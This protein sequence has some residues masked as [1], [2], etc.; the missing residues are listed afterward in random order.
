MLTKLCSWTPNDRA[1]YLLACPEFRQKP[2]N[3]FL[4]G[5]HVTI[6]SFGVFDQFSAKKTAI[7]FEQTNVAVIFSAYT[8]A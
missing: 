6:T 8:H 2:R 1:S 4:S 3:T 5:V 7:F